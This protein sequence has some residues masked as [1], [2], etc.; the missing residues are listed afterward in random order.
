MWGDKYKILTDIQ[1]P[2]DEHGDMDFKVAGTR[3]GVTA[4]QMD[5]KVDGIP[6]NILNEAFEKAKI[7][8]LKII[9]RIEEEIREPRKEL[10]QRGI[11]F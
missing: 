7:A 2:E 6:L 1:G 11:A 5:V 8:R 10:S 9:N 3:D 4:V